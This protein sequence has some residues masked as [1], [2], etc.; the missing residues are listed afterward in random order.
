M[1]E[2]YNLL[3]MSHG[4]L[5]YNRVGTVSINCKCKMYAFI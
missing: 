4:W 5:D 3:F 1:K 2:I